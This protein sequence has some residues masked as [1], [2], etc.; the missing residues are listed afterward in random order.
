MSSILGFS[1]RL[2]CR[3][4]HSP[5]QN[6][7]QIER[8]LLSLGVPSRAIN[9]DL[10]RAFY[11]L[12][13]NFSHFSLEDFESILWPF[14][15][16]LL[17]EYTLASEFD[18]AHSAGKEVEGKLEILWLIAEFMEKTDHE[19]T[20][21]FRAFSEVEFLASSLAD[22]D[23]QVGWHLKLPNRIQ[24]N[25]RIDWSQCEAGCFVYVLRPLED[26]SKAIIVCRGTA[27]R[28]RSI[29]SFQS[30]INDFLPQMGGWGTSSLW[31]HLKSW[32]I[33]QRVTTVEIMGKSLGGTN[34]QMLATA[35]LTDTDIELKSVQTLQ[36]A[37]V[38]S[39]VHEIFERTLGSYKRDIDLTITRWNVHLKNRHVDVVPFLGGYH[40]AQT[41]TSTRPAGLSVRNIYVGE[42]DSHMALSKR[43][44]ILPIQLALGL[45]TTHSLQMRFSPSTP[46]IHIEHLGPDNLTGPLLPSAEPLRQ[47]VIRMF[48]W[49]LP[50]IS[51]ILTKRFE[52]TINKN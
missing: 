49:P 12:E 4:R 21:E 28:W 27:L 42:R 33:A 22:R 30:V 5:S 48:T 41:P 45:A 15:K 11:F 50:L 14:A 36:S 7:K 34:A 13:K 40:L 23:P 29:Q 32:L 24:K 1:F 26:P 18:H 17:N 10:L 44:W 47:S 43:S 46:P 3:Y 6:F 19:Q 35:I 31:P 8:E 20:P 37:G 38:E 39:K 52:K 25:W 51:D 2:D 16:T 9:A